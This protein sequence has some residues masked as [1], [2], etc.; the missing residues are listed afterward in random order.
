MKIMIHAFHVF[1][2]HSKCLGKQ[3]KTKQQSVFRCKK[4]ILMLKNVKGAI[5][6]ILCEKGQNLQ[7][8][9]QNIQCDFYVEHA[10]VIPI[11]AMTITFSFF[12]RH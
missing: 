3:N 2:F 8:K 10:V 1:H 7:V 5:F 9:K 6:H 11:L 12:L 4:V